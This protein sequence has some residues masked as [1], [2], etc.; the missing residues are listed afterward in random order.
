MA[1]N[2]S[3]GMLL[4]KLKG[5]VRDSQDPSFS[6]NADGMYRQMLQRTQET[7]YDDFDWPFLRV[8]DTTL[9]T[10][11]GERYYNVPAAMNMERIESLWVFWSSQWRMLERGVTEQ[12]YNYYNPDMNVRVDP[13]LKWDVVDTGNGEQIELWPLPSSTLPMHV[14]GIRKLKPLLADADTADLDDNMLALYCA[15]EILADK[16][17]ADA[18]AKLKAAQARYQRLKGRSTSGNT[19]FNLNGNRDGAVRR[20]GPIRVAVATL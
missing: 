15:S 17:A 14:I 10:Q 20:P 6:Q 11:A 18:G 4:N 12:D 5:E 3:L 9:S 16:K 1:R 2:T 7:L 8:R 19:S 13:V